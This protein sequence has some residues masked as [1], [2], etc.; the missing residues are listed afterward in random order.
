MPEKQKW[1]DEE[2]RVA[3]IDFKMAFDK[4]DR[5]VLQQVLEKAGCPQQLTGTIHS[6]HYGIEI[7]IKNN[8]TI[9]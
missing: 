7:A 6:R 5:Y 3:L 1:Y 9:S 8:Y 2:T 4:V